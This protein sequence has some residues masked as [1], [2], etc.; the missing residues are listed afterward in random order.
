MEETQLKYKD[1]HHPKVVERVREFLQTMPFEELDMMLKQRPEG[2]VET[3]M[4]ADLAE[5]YRVQLDR[6]PVKKSSVKAA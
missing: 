2:V 3:N 5:W 1:P 4:N 6:T